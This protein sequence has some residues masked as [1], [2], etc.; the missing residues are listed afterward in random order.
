MVNHKNPTKR[1]QKKSVI[2]ASRNVRLSFWTAVLWGLVLFALLS[3]LSPPLRA[4]DAAV[5]G[6]RTD[7]DGAPVISVRPFAG[8]VGETLVVVGGADSEDEPFALSGGEIRL[9]DAVSLFE[10]DAQGNLRPV[11]TQLKL[12]APTAFGVGVTT[13]L[14]LLLVGGRTPDGVTT[15]CRLLTRNPLDGVFALETFPDYPTPIAHAQGALFENRVYIA[16]GLVPAADETLAPTDRVYSLDLSRRGAPDWGWTSEPN[17]PSPRFDA[18][19]AVQNRNDERKGLFLFGGRAVAQNSREKAETPK[20]V[21]TPEMAE[22]SESAVIDLSDAFGFVPGDDAWR[23]VDVNFPDEESDR[24]ACSPIPFSIPAIASGTTHLLFFGGAG[25]KTQDSG[26]VGI[27]AYNV[28]TNRLFSLGEMAAPLSPGTAAVRWGSDYLSV[29]G[30]K[31]GTIRR[32]DIQKRRNRLGVTNIVVIAVYF[33]VLAWM[34]YYFSKRQKGTEDYFRGGE[35]VP[36]WAVGVSLFGASLSAISYMAV[37]AKSYM[38]NWELIFLSSAY[39]WAAPIL[40]LFF[41]PRLRRYR[42]T[43]AYEYLEKRFNVVVRALGSGIFIAFQIVRMAIM[44]FLP[45]I[46]INVVTNFDILTCIILVGAV[47][48]VYTM[49]GG[50]EAVIWTDVLQVFILMGGIVLAVAIVSFH[51]DGGFWDIL[52]VGWEDRKFHCA[53]FPFVWNRPTIWVILASSFFIFIVPFSSD[54]TM[55]QRYF[56]GKGNPDTVRGLWTFACLTLPGTALLFFLGTAFYVFYKANPTA[57][58]VLLDNNDSLLPWFVITQM[59]PGVSG[60]LIVAIL[61][62]SM[63]SLSASM[64]SIAAAWTVDFHQRILK[65]PESTAMWTARSSTL[66]SGALAIFLAVA[67]ATWDIGSFWDE[68][69]RLLGLVTSSLAG[70]F[71][72][73]LLSRRANTLGAITGLVLSFLF[74]IYVVNHRLVYILLYSGTGFVSAIVFGYLASLL[75]GRAAPKR[76]DPERRLDGRPLDD[77]SG[78]PA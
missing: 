70:I 49:F 52:R 14:G 72:L 69:N 15:R 6:T 43:S 21:G 8:T 44:L 29:G 26:M 35:R 62:A 48:V 3:S 58:S 22:T 18:P 7:S 5:L 27:R 64:N 41:I 68:Y 45:A 50:I 71:F 34:G 54:Q 73:G 16:G 76:D 37:P 9:T 20:T 38:T 63:S 2:H 55:V 25:A 17:L 24:G 53:D 78:P 11:S 65:F 4:S 36:W 28:I 57:A 19:L 12:P 13:D 39:L 61:A 66:V 51:L 42:L 47:S 74:Q 32:V 46:A 59:P 75:F 77:E 40:T 23:T 33:A 67:M 60:L 30:G 1:R 10:K 56:V 31:D